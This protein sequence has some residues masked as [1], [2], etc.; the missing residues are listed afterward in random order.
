M[1][2]IDIFLL[3]YYSKIGDNPAYLLQMINEL[4]KEI[5]LEIY[6]KITY[7]KDFEELLK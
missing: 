4:S 6:K 1:K 7:N 5:K 2:E 3:D